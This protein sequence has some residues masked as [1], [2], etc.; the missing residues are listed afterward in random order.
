MATFKMSIKPVSLTQLGLRAGKRGPRLTVR[1]QRILFLLGE[2]GCVSADRIKSHFWNSSTKSRAHYR[3]LGLLMR[4]QLVENVGGD[5]F[6]TLGYR[7]TKKG[8]A[9]L[10][11][12]SGRSS[13]M[14]IRRNYKTQFDHDQMLIDVRGILQE[15][16]L[17][18]DF[19]S[20]SEIRHE[21]VSETVRLL[22]WEKQPTIPDASFI[23][24]VPGKR[25][26]VAVELELTPKFRKRYTKIFRG[27][28]LSQDWKL[29]IYI[30]RD[31]NLRDRIMGILNDIKVNDIQVRVAKTVNGI[32]FCSLDDFLSMRLATPLT[33]GKR[34]ISLEQIAQN[35]GLKNG[36]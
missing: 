36:K 5:R 22:N 15:S 35:F 9:V 1:D 25:I 34:E 12:L 18:R 21:L 7:L 31:K 27:H 24:E 14:F 30:V 4:W 10:V 8:R 28:L 2:Y 11:R 33:N 16:P 32:Y 17:V 23:F 29:V 13:S 19:K 6:K 3:R 26:C 20:E